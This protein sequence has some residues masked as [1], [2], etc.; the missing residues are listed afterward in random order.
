MKFTN[1]INIRGKAVSGFILN[2][3]L[4]IQSIN[5]TKNSVTPDI[6]VLVTKDGLDLLIEELTEIKEKMKGVWE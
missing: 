1:Q 4:I 5:P 3:E 2:D 6:K